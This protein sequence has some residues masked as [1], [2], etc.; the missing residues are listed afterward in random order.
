MLRRY[1]VRGIVEREFE[2]DGAPY[3]AWRHTLAEEDA[4]L[5]QAQSGQLI[6]LGGGVILEVISPPA[7]LL[8]GTTSDVDNA[9]VVLRLVYR[10]V[11]FLLTGDMFSDGEGALVR[12]DVPMDSD[13]LK[14]GH[15]GSRGSSSEAFLNGVSPSVAVVSAGENNQFGHPH[16]ETIQTLLRHVPDN[17]LFSTADNGTIEFITDGNSLEV[18]TER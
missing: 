1:D 5:I 18:K 14:V 13:V 11:S 2:Y 15:H 17:L 6:D 9:S 8:R 12:E 10:D 7:R 4:A 3:Q 16:E